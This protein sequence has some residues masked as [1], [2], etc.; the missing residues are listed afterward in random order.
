MD[1]SHAKP[2]KHA[3]IWRLKSSESWASSEVVWFG[4]FPDICLKVNYL[5]LIFH[6]IPVIISLYRVNLIHKSWHGLSDP[7]DNS[8][9]SSCSPMKAWEHYFEDFQAFNF[10]QY[11]LPSTVMIKLK[12]E[13]FWRIAWQFYM[14]H[15]LSTSDEQPFFGYPWVFVY[16]LG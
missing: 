6:I 7:C 9:K 1:W 5:V 11:F 4:C 16:N 13:I 15:S 2:L 3:H 10:Q 14:A 12:S 8:K